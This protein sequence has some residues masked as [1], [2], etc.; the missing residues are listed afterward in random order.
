[1][2]ASKLDYARCSDTTDYSSL[3]NYADVKVESLALDWTVDFEASVLKG[4]ATLE[5]TSTCASLAKVVL[6]TRDLSV[7]SVT[8]GGKAVAFAL[9]PEVG[10]FG[11]ALAVTLAGPLASGKS[12]TVSKR[13]TLRRRTR[14][15]YFSS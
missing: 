12:A 3:A 15:M 11:Q 10:C 14:W 5:V 1:M 2:A 7:A 8:V 9:G 13:A 6:D 4:S